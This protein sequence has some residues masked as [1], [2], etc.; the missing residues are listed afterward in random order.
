MNPFDK[1]VT[2]H[3]RTFIGT[4]EEIVEPPKV[5]VETES[6]NVSDQYIRRIQLASENKHSNFKR[7]TAD[8]DVAVPEHL[9]QLFESSNKGLSADESEMLRSTLIHFADVFSKGEWNIG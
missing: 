2:L 7:K 6:N 1:P 4:A 5:L 8:E 3:Q 9:Q